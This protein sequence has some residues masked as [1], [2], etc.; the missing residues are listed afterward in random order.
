MKKNKFILL[1][2]VSIT[3]ISFSK[4]S[5]VMADTKIQGRLNIVNGY[6][7]ECVMH[8]FYTDTGWIQI[9]STKYGNTENTGQKIRK[10]LKLRV[11]IT[12]QKLRK[13]RNYGSGDY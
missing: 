6:S 2:L 8:K 9:G 5:V 1:F 7:A 12:G 10:L 13:L 4:S 11:K 3:T